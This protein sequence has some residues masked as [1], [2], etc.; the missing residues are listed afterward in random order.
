[1]TELEIRYRSRQL[2]RETERYLSE[3]ATSDEALRR[4]VDDDNKGETA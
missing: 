2:V 4:V 3:I 1:M